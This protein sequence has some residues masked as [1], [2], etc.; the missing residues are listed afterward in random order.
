MVRSSIQQLPQHGAALTR[1]EWF[2]GLVLMIQGIG[3]PGFPAA[4]CAALHHVIDFQH[5][6]TFAYNG[7]DTPLCL[8]H[9]FPEQRYAIHVIDYQSGPYILDPLYKACTNGIQSGVFRLKD[10]A[11]DQFY[12]SEYYRSYYVQTGPVDEVAF[13]SRCNQTWSVITSLMRP[14]S[15]RRFSEKELRQLCIIEPLI[16]ELCRSH[17]ETDPRLRSSASTE[18]PEDVLKRIVQSALQRLDIRPLTPR[19]T[20]V[21][22]L[23]LQGHSSESIG[24]ILQIAT[25]TVRIHRKNIYAKMRIS[26]QRELFLTF[27][28]HTA[29]SDAVQIL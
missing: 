7:S 25:G 21:V 19:E 6:V 12:K 1:A 8:S 26:S 15:D 23:V 24:R 17:W 11:P 28:G 2:Q 14:H 18:S 20:E 13:F 3:T 22:G 10:V 4:L 5:T 16:R 9:D 27:I 29:R